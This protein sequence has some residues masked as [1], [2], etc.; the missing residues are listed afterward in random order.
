MAH[1]FATDEGPGIVMSAI[2]PA[3]RI[4]ATPATGIG[5]LDESEV[6]VLAGPGTR[7][8]QRAD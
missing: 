6:V 5:C 4:I 2:V 1:Q 7:H 3:G 8:W